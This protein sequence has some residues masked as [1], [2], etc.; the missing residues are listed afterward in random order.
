MYSL[1]RC[2]VTIGKTS[3]SVRH[4]IDLIEDRNWC[5]STR[6]KASQGPKPDVAVFAALVLRKSHF[7]SKALFLNVRR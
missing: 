3:E 5:T 6:W 1:V 4:D 2:E 7:Q